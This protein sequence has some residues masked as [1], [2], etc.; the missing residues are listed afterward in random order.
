MLYS[1]LLPKFEIELVEIV[2]RLLCYKSS[3]GNYRN[4]FPCCFE[5][6]KQC[7]CFCVVISLTLPPPQEVFGDLL[8]VDKPLQNHVLLVLI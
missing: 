8:P 1:L 7:I 6:M 2:V 5:V 3:S 4:N